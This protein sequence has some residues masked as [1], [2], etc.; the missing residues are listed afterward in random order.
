MSTPD[1]IAKFG[2]I[3]VYP[4]ASNPQQLAV[5]MRDETEKWGRVV[6]RSE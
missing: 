6:R 3:G 4:D 5:K 2:A 1:V